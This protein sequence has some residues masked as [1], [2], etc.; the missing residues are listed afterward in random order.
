MNIEEI[1][2]NVRAEV[3]RKFDDPIARME[4][5]SEKSLKYAEM[6]F[7]A[8]RSRNRL[9]IEV[10]KKYSE[11]YRKMKFDSAYL[12]KSKQDVDSFID[13]DE[14][15]GKIKNQL[16]EWDN[17]VEFL[18]NLVDIYKNREATERLIFKFKTG[19]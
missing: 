6:L 7:R 3:E 11:I 19:V 2:K 8:T 17:L 5:N 10:D 14:E 9:K 13:T 12:L 1:L 18:A 4:S 16:K 15:Y